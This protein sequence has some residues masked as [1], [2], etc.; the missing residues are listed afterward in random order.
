MSSPVDVAKYIR[1]IPRKYTFGVSSLYPKKVSVWVS[2]L[3][4]PKGLSRYAIYPV[5]NSLS[6]YINGPVDIFCPF[7]VSSG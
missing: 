3:K 6:P 4:V 1:F 7:M 2:Y 5:V